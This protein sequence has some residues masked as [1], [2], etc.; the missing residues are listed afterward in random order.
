MDS[1]NN[2]SLFRRK[3]QAAREKVRQMGGVRE[4][5]GILA[6]FEELMQVA[7]RNRTQ[8]LMP[9]MMQQPRPVRFQQGGDIA[10]EALRQGTPEPSLGQQFSAME[11]LSMGQPVDIG[12][13]PTPR[14]PVDISARPTPRPRVEVPDVAT[15]VREQLGDNEEAQAKFSNVVDAISNPEAEP[16][17][18]QE[19]VTSA[20]G[21]ENTTDKY[22]EVISQ[23]TG[24]DVPASATVD[25][26]NQAITGVALGGAIGGPRSVAERISNALLTGLQA[27]RETAMG[28]EA[29]EAQIALAELER[30]RRSPLEGLYSDSTSNLETKHFGTIPQFM[31]T[32]PGTLSGAT[33]IIAG[34]QDRIIMTYNNAMDASDRL[35]ELSAEAENLLTMEDVA[36]FEGSASR[37]LSRAAAA[38]PSSV[39]DALGIDKDNPQASAAQRFDVIQRTLAAQLAPMLLGESGRT[40]SDGDR[41]RVARL[42]GIVSED[43]EGLGLNIKDLVSGSFR[44]EAELL[45]AI[46]EVNVILQQNRREVESEFE[47]LASR[48]P[49][50]QIQRPEAPAA[51]PAP[52][53]SAPG[54][55]SIVLTEE[56]ITQYGG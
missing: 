20:V 10:M 8:N 36:G 27:E 44:S 11:A 9:Q 14:G 39:A 5:Q 3:S 37:A 52:A 48:I 29:V 18:I 25:E 4:P 40:I 34:E 19:A 55:T 56:D 47:M 33:P 38:L 15:M 53:T 28:R 6:S 2:R 12:A 54:S 22:R 13:T 30:S 35:L 1:V 51:T 16:E 32:L 31:P 43:K 46:R 17:Q 50:L 42:L 7:G 21:V 24:R 23:I 26:L 49:G 45:E 41:A